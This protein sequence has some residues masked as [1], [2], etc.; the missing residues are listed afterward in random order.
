[1]PKEFSATLTGSKQIESFLQNK[2]NISVEIG[3][4]G[5]RRFTIQMG[6]EEHP[7]QL[8]SL[9]EQVKTVVEKEKDQPNGKI[10][11]WLDRKLTESTYG[12]PI[13]G[14]GEL[15]TAL[16]SIDKMGE[17]KQKEALRKTGRVR[18]LLIALAQFRQKKQ[19]E[20]ITKFFYEIYHMGASRKGNIK[21][22]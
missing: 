19:Q 13:E 14:P 18:R 21:T 1:M 3:F 8:G 10:S 22:T 20:K 5:G 7:F 9:V 11:E 2:E 15:Q 12:P 4:L 17:Q 16:E 6:D